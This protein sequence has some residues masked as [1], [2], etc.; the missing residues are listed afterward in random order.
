MTTGLLRLGVRKPVAPTPGG[1]IVAEL[2]GHRVGA[3]AESPIST[4]G[5]EQVQQ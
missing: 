5:H 3:A 4:V 1:Y 2:S